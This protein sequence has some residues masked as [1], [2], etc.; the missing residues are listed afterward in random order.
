MSRQW[1]VR[2]VQPIVGIFAERKYLQPSIKKF[3][4]DSEGKGV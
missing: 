2:Q 1:A 3:I 4:A